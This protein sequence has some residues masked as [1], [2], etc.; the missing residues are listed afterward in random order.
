M[1]YGINYFVGQSKEWLEDQL[2]KCS[3][4]MNLRLA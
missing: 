4:F 1:S 3:L 2:A